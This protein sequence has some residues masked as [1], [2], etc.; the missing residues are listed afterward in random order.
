MF[1]IVMLVVLTFLAALGIGFI[2]IGHFVIAS[3][4]FL[5]CL[6]TIVFAFEIKVTIRG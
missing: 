5:C 4:V 6:L 3:V 1:L 2:L